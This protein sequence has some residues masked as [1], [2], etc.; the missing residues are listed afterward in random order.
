MT[1]AGKAMLLSG[2]VCPGLGQWRLGARLKGALMAAAVIGLVMVLGVKVFHT[3]WEV[4]APGGD[5]MAARFTREAIDEA[6]KEAYL[7]NW[8]VLLPIVAV[9]LYGI[10]D[11]RTMGRK[12][13]EWPS[14]TAGPPPG[15]YSYPPPLEDNPPDKSRE[16]PPKGSE[17]GDP[18]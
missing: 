5:I 9:W 13:S 3:V 18:P 11:A 2:L 10:F 1:P 15:Y 16:K 7:R 17:G 8:W 4:L 12:V 14:A 6:H